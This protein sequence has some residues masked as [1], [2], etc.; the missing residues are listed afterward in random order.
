MTEANSPKNTSEIIAADLFRYGGVSGSKQFIKAW[1]LHPGFRYTY[2]LRKGAKHKPKSVLGRVYQLICL[3][4]SIKYGI[5]IPIHTQIGSGFYIGHFGN[6]VVNPKSIIGDNCN[7]A[8]GVTIGQ[9]NRGK[10]VGAPSIGDKVWIGPNS[11]IV[12]DVKIG[13]NVLIAPNAF[14]NFDVPDDSIVVTQKC[15][16]ISSKS[17]TKDYIAFTGG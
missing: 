11:V 2:F 3:H 8:Q 4:Y 9:A 12:G 14:V 1:L 7:I 16:V 5:Q 15:T 6:I 17:A 10:N 13:N